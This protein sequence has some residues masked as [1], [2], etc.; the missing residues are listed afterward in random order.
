MMNY[1][2]MV[3]LTRRTTSIFACLSVLVLSGC[4][5][6]TEAEGQV[7]VPSVVERVTISE[8]QSPVSDQIDQIDPAETEDGDTF[9]PV[10][11]AE[12]KE[13]NDFISRI[14]AYGFLL[15]EYASPEEVSLGQVFYMGAGLFEEPSPEEVAAYLNAAGQEEVFT[16]CMKMDAGRVEDLLRR[17]LDCEPEELDL[18]EV[19]VY[20]PDYHAYFREE[21]DVN[22]VKYECTSAIRNAVDGYELTL[23]TDDPCPEGFSA[24]RTV[25]LRHGDDFQFI[26]NECTSPVEAD[27][28]VTEE[29]DAGSEDTVTKAEELWEILYRER[30]ST[31]EPT[32]MRYGLDSEFSVVLDAGEK[33]FEEGG[34]KMRYE[35]LVSFMGA[36]DD[37]YQFWW[38]EV[39]YEG[40]EV[41]GTKTRGWFWMDEASGK[42]INEA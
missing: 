38:Y 41:F 31:Y 23:H 8:D 39:Y 2:S 12:L 27:D 42:I 15:S 16:T 7:A 26:M 9:E 24:L 11:A 18:S 33:S 3:E 19:G 40:E 6:K 13:L 20:L 29:G 10:S 36:D 32:E 22:F 4:G 14:D 34:A 30:F 28:G 17:R 1:D 37:G 25:L 5:G 21:A 35:N